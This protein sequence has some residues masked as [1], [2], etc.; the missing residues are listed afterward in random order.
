M[1][2]KKNPTE[3]EEWSLIIFFTLMP[4]LRLV[5]KYIKIMHLFIK[6]NDTD[7]ISPISNILDW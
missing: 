7:T 5:S 4:I 1:F 6:N 3:N 2:Q